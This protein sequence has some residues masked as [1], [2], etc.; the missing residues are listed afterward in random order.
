MPTLRL[1][2]LLCVT[3]AA[4]LACRGDFESGGGGATTGGS[5]ESGSDGSGEDGGSGGDDGGTSGG[6]D[7]G[8]TGSDGG[9]STGDS[10]SGDDGTTDDGSSSG[11]GGT[12]T[13][14]EG[15]EECELL[16]DKIVG[17]TAQKHAQDVYD[18]E[19]DPEPVE[20]TCE[21]VD[22][23]A[24][25]EEC[26][27]ECVAASQSP[28]TAACVSCLGEL[29]VCFTT[30][31][32]RPCDGSCEGT[33]LVTGYDFEGVPEYDYWTYF[34]DDIDDPALWDCQVS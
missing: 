4:I 34:F 10:G 33:P 8:G 2:S 22:R 26:V 17:C 16:C 5:G 6:A 13:T 18:E 25:Y 24:A 12:T 32:M 15:R 9:D 23:D 20:V 31:P 29:L 28:A 21:W 27:T 11:D 14:E 7:D 19:Y 3:V 30:G 1:S